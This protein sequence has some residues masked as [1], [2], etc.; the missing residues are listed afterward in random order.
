[1]FLTGG[2][3]FG[4]MAA[5]YAVVTTVMLSG[6]QKVESYSTDLNAQRAV[7]AIS[8]ATETLTTKLADWSTWD[9]TYQFVEDLNPAFVESNLTAKS[10]TSLQLTAMVF[11]RPDHSVAHAVTVK[12]AETLVSEAPAGLIEC[13]QATP[14]ILVEGDGEGTERSGVL[15]WGG[16]IYLVASR[17]ILTSDAKGPSH[18]TL[19]FCEELTAERIEEMGHRLRMGL[20]IRLLAPDSPVRQATGAPA[21]T[22]TVLDEGQI[23]GTA[24]VNDLLNVPALEVEV[25]LPRYVYA[26]ARATSRLLGFTLALATFVCVAVTLLVLRTTVLGRLARLHREV[27]GIGASCDVGARVTVVGHDELSH[28][29]STLNDLLESI[30]DAHCD[31]ASAKAAAER[32]NKAKSEFLANMSHEVRTPL[33]AI[34]GFS[35][36]LADLPSLDENSRESIETIRRNGRHLLAVINDILDLSKIEAGRM[37]VELRSCSPVLVAREVLDLLRE[38]ATTKG[39]TVNLAISGDVPS[40]IT[41]DSLRFRQ[42]LLNLAGNAIKFTHAGGVTIR[43]EHDPI[44]SL[45]LADVCDTGIGI[46]KEQEARLF[47]SF[48]QAEASTARV[49]GGTGLGLTISRK[50][51][52]L[53]GGSVAL[54]A[55][56]PKGSTFRI[57]IAT[58]ALDPHAEFVNDATVAD[59]LRLCTRELDAA[60]PA[61]DLTGVRM[62]LA[63]DGPDNQRLI[64]FVLRKAGATVEIVGDG[65]AAVDAALAARQDGRPFDLILMD[66]QLPVLDGFAA[67]RALRA[68]NVA[69]PILALTAHAM[70][71]DRSACLSAGCNDYA[72]KPIDRSSLLDLCSRLTRAAS[73]GETRKAA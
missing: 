45:L 7:A 1:M 13:I 42:I 26:E 34:L 40:L 59:S 6:F 16:G 25:T 55:T 70:E 11:L 44:R 23:R 12:D 57:A 68:A 71:G 4:L 65:Q 49:Y 38:R 63:E 20:A 29:A 56:G 51:A 52:D 35:D 39:I 62:L 58:G 37:D 9:D 50:L 33:T 8:L 61:S 48:S 41:T 73:G 18:G 3:L 64:G 67:T 47:A 15:T 46:S 19:L 43:L 28:L 5:L 21:P 30:A 17:P 10:L 72:S 14:A 53:L 69:T 31:L 27:S 54:H 66:I 36:L 32:A 2:A 22:I 60:L 24:I